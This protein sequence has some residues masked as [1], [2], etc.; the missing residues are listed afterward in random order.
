MLPK[1]PLTS[2]AGRSAG[3]SDQFTVTLRDAL[4][5][6]LPLV[7][8]TVMVPVSEGVSGDEPLFELLLPPQLT[9]A[10]NK[11]ASPRARKWRSSAHLGAETPCRRFCHRRRKTERRKLAADA[12]EIMSHQPGVVDIP[13]GFRPALLTGAVIVRVDV[14]LAATEAALTEQVVLPRLEATVQVKLTVPAKPFAAVT[15]TVDEPLLP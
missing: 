6:L 11:H 8:V 9:A 7:P 10:P 13:R 14:P 3:A 5:L 1:S 15:V 2:Q 12:S 4:W